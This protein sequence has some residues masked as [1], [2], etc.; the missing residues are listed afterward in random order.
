MIVSF[1]KNKQVLFIN[2]FS[3]KRVDITLARNALNGYQK[4][5]CFYSFKDLNIKDNLN[6][7]VDHV[8]PHLNKSAHY[9]SK[10]PADINGVWNLVLADKKIN[11][12]EKSAKFPAK[13]YMERLH[14]R[15][16]YYITSKHPLAETII[17]QTGKTEVERL[18]FLN[19]HWNLAKENCMVEFNSNE[20]P[21]N[22]L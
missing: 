9:F 16:E 12:H 17:N 7:D 3:M 1:D 6:C 22:K 19:F 15:N 14:T 4:G 11:R 13:K 5:K 18:R 2:D 10:Y 8:L 20:F 21:E